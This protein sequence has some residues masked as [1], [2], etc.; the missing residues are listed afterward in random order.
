MTARIVIALILCFPLATAVSAADVAGGK[1][2][3]QPIQIK[4]NSLATD[5]GKRSAI[6]TGN[7][8]ARQGDIIIYCDR[9]VIYYSDKEKD[10]DKVEAFGDVRIIQGDRTAQ[11]GHAV[12][13]GRAGKIILDDNPKMYQGE[14]EIS[15]KV[16]TY[17]FET[18]RSEVTSDPDKRV[19]VI[20]HPKQKGK[21]G[22][23]SP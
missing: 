22:S 15:G 21:D 16:I 23:A 7:V 14:N 19:T 2:K 18:Q 3:N 9:M 13:D 12:Y 5:S 11:A 17:Y 4:S 6:F 8:S 20:I 1:R 10:V